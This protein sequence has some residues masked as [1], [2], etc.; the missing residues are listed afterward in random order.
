M[1]KP[2]LPSRRPVTGVLTADVLTDVLQERRKV[3][4]EEAAEA[5]AAAK[6]KAAQLREKVRQ[7]NQRAL[8]KMESLRS[9]GRTT[10]EAANAAVLEAVRCQASHVFQDSQ[11]DT[12]LLSTHG[13]RRKC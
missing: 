12:H 2:R 1:A 3:Q 7:A 8:V 4:E 11:G 9:E 6:A 5:E 10:R 13:C